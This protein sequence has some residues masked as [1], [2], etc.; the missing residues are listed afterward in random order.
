MNKDEDIE[1][2]FEKD[3]DINISHD[4]NDRAEESMVQFERDV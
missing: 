3:V 4:C 1:E 2:D